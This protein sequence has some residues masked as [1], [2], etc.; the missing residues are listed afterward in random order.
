VTPVPAGRLTPP[1]NSPPSTSDPGG[2][3]TTATT[4][5]PTLPPPPVTI[6][7]RQF[8]GGRDLL[9]VMGQDG[10]MS[11]WDPALL[12]NLS[13]SYRVTIF[14]LPGAGYSGSDADGVPTVEQFS[15]VTAGLIDAL[16]LSHPIVL[17]WGMGGE[18]ALALAARHPGLA[19]MLVLADTS[20][21]GAQGTR[22]SPAVTAAFA[23]PSTTTS[24]LANYLFPPGA[25]AALRSWS[26]LTGLESPDDIVAAA[27]TTE[28]AAQTSWWRAGLATAQ[29]AQMSIPVLV[30]QGSADQLFPSRNELSLIQLLPA[31]RQITYPAAGYAAIFEEDTQFVQALRAFTGS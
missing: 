21:G 20:A 22:P 29:A 8:G 19:S 13:H 26:E 14:D 16:G 10:T 5:P 30:V 17:G 27:V 15:D 1:P 18:V 2:T 4:T 6:G 23:D 11:W 3:G 28:A 31:A 7:Y 25:L 24:A 12:L 9:L